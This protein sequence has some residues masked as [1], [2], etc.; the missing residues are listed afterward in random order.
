MI[1]DDGLLPLS[2]Q[3][4]LSISLSLWWIIIEDLHYDF[5]LSYFIPLLC[6]KAQ[7]SINF[8]LLSYRC[9]CRF[10]K[11]Q[12]CYTLFP[13][14][15]MVSRRMDMREMTPSEYLPH[16]MSQKM[17]TGF[18]GDQSLILIGKIS[19]GISLSEMTKKSK[20]KNQKE[21]EHARTSYCLEGTIICRETF[22]FLHE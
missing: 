22:K 13:P 16:F 17:H 21:R 8:F 5:F 11:G 1:V 18:L 15:E 3:P 20:Q 9:R 2:P 14:E 6:P 12:P 10:N 4:L 19:C 7:Q